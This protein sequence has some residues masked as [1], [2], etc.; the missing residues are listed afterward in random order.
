MRDLKIAW[1]LLVG[2]GAVV[3]VI[4]VFGAYTLWSNWEARQTAEDAA[5]NWERTVT[6]REIQMYQLDLQALVRGVIITRN[7][8]LLDLYEERSDLLTERVARF[9]ELSAGDPQLQA[10]AG[11]LRGAINTLRSQVYGRQLRLAMDPATNEQAAEI[12]RSGEGWPPLET[13][14]KTVDEVTELQRSRL[15]AADA[16]QEAKFASQALWTPIVLLLAILIAVI[17]AIGP[18]RLIA[19]PIKQIAAV[20]RRMA[21]GD[22]G[23]PIP[24]GDRQDEI[25]DIATALKVFKE[26]LEQTDALQREAM[27]RQEEEVDRGRRV[28]EITQSFDADV[29]EL[30]GAMQHASGELQRMSENMNRVAADAGSRAATVAQ[31]SGETTANVQ[32]V[33]AATTELSASIS[34]ISGQV[35]KASEVAQDTAREAHSTSEAVTELDGMA[36]RIGQIVTLIRDISEQTNLLALNA[37]I[38]S[39]RAGEAGK[40]F[41]VVAS[42]VKSLANQTGKATEDISNQISAIQDRTKTAVAAIQSIAERVSDLER[43]TSALAAAVE[44]QNAATKEISANIEGVSQSAG[45]VSENVSYVSDSAHETGGMASEVMMAS[46]QVAS[47]SEGLGSRVQNFLQQVRSV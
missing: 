42:E 7:D 43:I 40:G 30:I 18:A 47:Q 37:T 35:S 26:S 20:M 8:Y 24:H 46:K 31:A 38:E 12:E 32:T 39:A 17:F 36:S 27:A 22:R 6:L 13:V 25:G 34:E 41:A 15:Q 9:E 2:T 11:R 29:G 14:L 1:K 23:Q 3:A 21:E 10:V 44:E 16:A 33:S 28:S 5:L 19:T 45:E 4:L